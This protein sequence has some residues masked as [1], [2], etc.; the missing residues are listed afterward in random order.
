MSLGESWMPV[1]KNYF[2][3]AKFEEKLFSC[4]F[5]F[6]LAILLVI[7]FYTI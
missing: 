1:R 7:N 3:K 4:Y 2:I 6:P 5:Q